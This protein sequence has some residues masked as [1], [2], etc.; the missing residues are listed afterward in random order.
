MPAEVG[1]NETRGLRCKAKRITFFTLYIMNPLTLLH[2]VAPSLPVRAAAWLCLF[3]WIPLPAQE[4]DFQKLEHLRLVDHP[5]NDGDSFRV[6]DGENEFYLRLYFVDCAE[7][8]ADTDSMARR[9]RE[10]TR[11]FGLDDHSETIRFGNL[12]TERM[13]EELAEPFTAY[14]RFADAMGAST[15]R[16]IFAFVVTADGEDLDKLLVREGLARTYGVGRRDYRGVHRD[17]R[18]AFLRDLELEAMLERRGIWSVSNPTR[19]ASLR[20]EQRRED[21]EL[22]QIRQEIGLGGLAEG[23][24]IS[25]NS[26]SVDELQRLP[27]IGPAFAA[28]I[29]EGRPY[30]SL[31]DLLNVPGIGSARLERLRAYLSLEE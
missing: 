24:T 20:A 25:I 22:H 14:T 9:V 31:D 19:L 21:R 28:R 4:E 5:G 27:G 15:T 13:R 3:F 29:V 30:H 17:E 23:E 16:R 10:Q 18:A 2:R 8:N 26:A 1:Q 7:T 12:A 11:Y 6:T